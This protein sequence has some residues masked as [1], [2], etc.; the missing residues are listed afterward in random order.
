MISLTPET[1]LQFSLLI[2]RT[3]LPNP[4]CNSSII[5]LYCVFSFSSIYTYAWYPSLII[6]AN[7]PV[8]ISI[9]GFANPPTIYRLI[10]LSSCIFYNLAFSLYSLFAIASRYLR[11]GIKVSLISF[12]SCF[13]S[14]FKLLINFMASARLSFE[15]CSLIVS[16]L[17]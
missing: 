12:F 6:S 17:S 1:D 5:S 16:S 7:D 13:L 8:S 3:I 9:A 15:S 4:L 2:P 11:R 10:D 14:S